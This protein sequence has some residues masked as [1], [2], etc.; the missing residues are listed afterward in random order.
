MVLSLSLHV[1]GIFS[2]SPGTGLGLPRG[3]TGPQGPGR[4]EY[5]RKGG[6]STEKRLES[7]LLI[8]TI[9]RL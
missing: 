8:D 4:A 9:I 2:L 3:K 5:D 6:P 1:R 7:I